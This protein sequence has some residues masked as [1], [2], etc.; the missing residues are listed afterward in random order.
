[1]AGIVVPNGGELVLT[2]QGDAEVWHNVMGLGFSPGFGV[3]ATVA[4]NIAIAVR[5][6]WGIAGGT[7]MRDLIADGIRLAGIKVVDLR[8]DPHPV[9]ERDG[10]ATAPS[11]GTTPLPVQTAVTVSL[12]TDHPGRSG[13][14][15]V[16]LAGW[17]NTRM[18]SGS[19]ALDAASAEAADG[20]ITAIKVNLETAFSGD[21]FLAVVSRKLLERFAVTTVRVKTNRWTTQRRRAA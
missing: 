2:W 11:G 8:S 18:A 17:V 3:D 4:E 21:V 14:G 10:S 19:F 7:P 6:A 13:R 9:F 20:F 15:R 1:M 12:S 16:Y 5:E